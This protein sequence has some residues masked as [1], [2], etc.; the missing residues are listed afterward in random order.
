MVNRY[1]E[2]LLVGRSAA[3]LLARN[4]G[5]ERS[6]ARRPPAAAVSAIRPAGCLPDQVAQGTHRRQALR[7][8]AQH[9]VR[10]TA[11]PRELKRQGRQRPAG[12]PGQ[13]FQRQL[14]EIPPRRHQRETGRA[15]P[16]GG[17][18]DTVEEASKPCR[19]LDIAA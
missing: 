18:G 13:Q 17:S 12:Q 11:L 9:Q 4:Q 2:R 8:A 15:G 19:G 3:V 10:R 6:V 1:G 7:R 16:D 14:G 5:R